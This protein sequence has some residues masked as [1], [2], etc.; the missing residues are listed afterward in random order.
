M[1]SLFNSSDHHA[2]RERLGTLAPMSGGHWGRMSSHQ[3]VCHLC[4]WFRGVLGD[5]PIPVEPPSLKTRTLRFIAFTTPLPWPKGFRTAPEQDQEKDGTAPIEFV[6][7]VDELSQLMDRFA[8]RRGREMT[9]HWR[10]GQMPAA[11]WGRYGYRHVD[12]HLRQ[13]GA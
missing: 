1:R 2:L 11:M 12:H 5:R 10:W 3:A 9:P 6:A 13:F 4:D 7:D 8:E